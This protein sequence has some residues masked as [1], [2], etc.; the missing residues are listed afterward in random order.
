M[1]TLIFLSSVLLYILIGATVGQIRERLAQKRCNEYNHGYCDH[2]VVSILF[3]A[4]WPFVPA[5]VL[6]FLA[7]KK[8]ST[9]L[10]DFFVKED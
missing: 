2:V 5:I 8:I 7:G 3:G 9:T 10:A 4:F 1:G 6:V